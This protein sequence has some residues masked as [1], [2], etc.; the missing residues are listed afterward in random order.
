MLWESTQAYDSG[1]CSAKSCPTFCDPMDCSLP[2]SSVHGNLQGR[3]LEWVA[4][5]ASRDLPY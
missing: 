4:I 5:S 3:V 1:W 2:S